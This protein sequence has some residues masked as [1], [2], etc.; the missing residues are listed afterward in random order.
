[1]QH[2][3]PIFF[4]L[5]E[6]Y[7]KDTDQLAY[8]VSPGDALAEGHDGKWWLLFDFEYDEIFNDKEQ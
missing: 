6:V 2:G 3:I 1:M 7:Y 8:Y 5:D 4:S